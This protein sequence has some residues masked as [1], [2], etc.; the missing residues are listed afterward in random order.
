MCWAL[1]LT[2]WPPQSLADEIPRPVDGYKI[3]LLTQNLGDITALAVIGND[4][5]ALDKN[6]DRILRLRDQNQDGTIDIQTVYLLGFEHAAH[7]VAFQNHL[8]ISDANGI[9]KSNVGKNLSAPTAPTN[10]VPFTAQS[11]SPLAVSKT[12]LYAGVMTAT[13]KGVVTINM[14]TNTVR[15]FAKSK[16]EIQALTTSP[17]GQLWAALKTNS[18]THVLKVNNQESLLLHPLKANMTAIDIKDMRL[19]QEKLLLA[20]ARPTPKIVQQNFAYGEL[21]D[22]PKPLVG[23][24]SKPSIAIGEIDIW[25]IPSA[26]AVLGN[27]NLLFADGENGHIW[28]VSK[29]KFSPH[30]AKIDQPVLPQATKASAEILSPAKPPVLIFG[31]SITSASSLN[32]GSAIGKDDLLKSK[33]QKHEK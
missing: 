23:L 16:W 30:A 18:G 31:S 6:K 2:I 33:K 21:T 12:A 7:M 8:Y 1:T 19:W 22:M 11:H 24:F 4:I 15:P 27:G 9:W 17:T 29:I 14:Y 13:F 10:I 25:G 5:F 3:N 26:M 20:I 32:H 28:E